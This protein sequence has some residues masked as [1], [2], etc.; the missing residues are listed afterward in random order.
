MTLRI[1]STGNVNQ[2][3]LTKGRVEEFLVRARPDQAYLSLFCGL[4]QTGQAL[5]PITT[6][7][8]LTLHAGLRR[9]RI[10]SSPGAKIER[11]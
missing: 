11:P 8:S 10:T 4:Q 1:C 9:R 3:A 6:A 2:P 5:S 7:N